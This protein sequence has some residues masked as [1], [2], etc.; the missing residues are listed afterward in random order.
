MIF[1]TFLQNIVVKIYALFPQMFWVKIDL[2]NWAKIYL[3]SWGR[4]EARQMMEEGFTATLPILTF[5]NLQKYTFIF[6]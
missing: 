2:K 1:V 4:I 6:Y 3:K 5:L